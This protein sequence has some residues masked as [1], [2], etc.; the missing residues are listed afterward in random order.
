MDDLVKVLV[1]LNNEV[2]ISG[3]KKPDLDSICSSFALALLLE[4]LNQSV[5][6]TVYIDNE[7]VDLI[8]DFPCLKRFIKNWDYSSK[9]YSFIALDLNNI[10]RLPDNIKGLTL[11]ANIAINIDHH[12]GNKTLFNTIYNNNSKSSTCEIIYDLYRLFKI[13]LNKNIAS[14]LFIGIISDTNMFTINS[15]HNL[16]NIISKLTKYDINPSYL[17]YKYYFALSSEEETAIAYMITNIIK[18]KDYSYITINVKLFPFDKISYEELSKKCLPII[19][20]DTSINLF[21][22]IVDYGNKKKGEIRS[23]NNIDI[24]PLANSLTGGGH[25]YA[26]GFSNEKSIEIILKICDNYFNKILN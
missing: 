12:E 5:D 24:E 17:I 1:K 8:N 21:L 4:K 7:N 6:I 3:H 10:D 18:R 25:K 26:A 2:I 19:L 11:N 13:K 23:K 16:F 9:N 22:M 14:L 20:N 15:S